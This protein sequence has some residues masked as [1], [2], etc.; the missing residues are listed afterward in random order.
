MDSGSTP[1]GFASNSGDDFFT[2]FPQHLTAK[3][4]AACRV[5]INFLS[6]EHGGTRLPNLLTNQD[7]ALGGNAGR[8]TGT[9]FRLVFVMGWPRARPESDRCLDVVRRIGVVSLT[10][11]RSITPA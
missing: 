8:K 6:S 2:S 11:G 3:A 1:E 4:E 9:T 10:P 7:V 5:H